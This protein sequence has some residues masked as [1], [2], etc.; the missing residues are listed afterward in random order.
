VLLAAIARL[1]EI[2]AEEEGKWRTEGVYYSPNS[3][4]GQQM[5]LGLDLLD[6]IKSDP[7]KIKKLAQRVDRPALIIHGENDAS[8]APSAARD[9]AAW[10]ENS[11]TIMLPG[12]DHNFGTSHPFAGSSADFERVIAAV[13]DFTAE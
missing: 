13:I 11:T 10:I 2:S 3:R 9:L 12:A 8:V 6:E 7:D 5:P 4:T 1:P